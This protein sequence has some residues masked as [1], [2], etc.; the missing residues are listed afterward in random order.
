MYRHGCCHQYCVRVASHA[1]HNSA[2]ANTLTNHSSA[3]A[4]TLTHTGIDQHS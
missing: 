3:P 2:P 4:N 1:N